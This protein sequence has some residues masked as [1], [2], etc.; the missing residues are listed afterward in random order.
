M[1]A[2]DDETPPAWPLP[3]DANAH[4][5]ASLDPHDL[6]AAAGV[7]RSWRAAARADSLWWP[8][9]ATLP[10]VGSVQEERGSGATTVPAH[11]LFA[12]LTLACERRIA[13]RCGAALTPMPP[14]RSQPRAH[15]SAS[16][17]T[18]TLAQVPFRPG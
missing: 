14:C 6:A 17:P 1:A 5:F 4:V 18:R 8:L 3:D 10:G 9:F 16:P 2:D 15:H 7:C 13:E 11:L 12:A